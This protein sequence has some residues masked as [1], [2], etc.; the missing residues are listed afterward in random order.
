MYV[1]IFKLSCLILKWWFK[2]IIML[3]KRELIIVFVLMCWNFGVFIFYFN[4]KILMID[5]FVVIGCFFV[6][7]DINMVFIYEVL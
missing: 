4:C 6:L 5:V 7:R 3:I 2:K 1:W